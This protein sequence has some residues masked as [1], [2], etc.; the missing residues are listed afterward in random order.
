MRLCRLWHALGRSVGRSAAC[1]VTYWPRKR[2]NARQNGSQWP[3]VTVWGLV[4]GVTAALDTVPGVPGCYHARRGRPG[5][6]FEGTRGAAPDLGPAPLLLGYERARTWHKTP[7]ARPRWARQRRQHGWGEVDHE[8]G[9]SV[10]M[11][12]WPGKPAKPARP[13]G[14]PWEYHGGPRVVSQGFV[15]SVV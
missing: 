14:M 1:Y 6:L 8:T 13:R 3:C 4:L 15:Y 2:Q 5:R 12:A 7:A 9:A 11:I 10:R